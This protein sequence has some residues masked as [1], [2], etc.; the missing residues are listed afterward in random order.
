MWDV[1]PTVH[2]F[3]LEPRERHALQ[4]YRDLSNLREDQERLSDVFARLGVRTSYAS[5]R[6]SPGAA[7]RSTHERR[8]Q[9]VLRAEHGGKSVS[10]ALKSEESTTNQHNFSF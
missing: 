10:H 5:A 6:H 3:P 2:D 9:G 8:E 4:D 7:K 1:C